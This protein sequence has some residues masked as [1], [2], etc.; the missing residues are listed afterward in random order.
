M[1]Y[2]PIKKLGRRIEPNIFKITDAFGFVN[3]KNLN[4]YD[5]VKLV[6][7]DWNIH[8]MPIH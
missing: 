5:E 7:K 3:Y 2:Y 1:N 6:T 4:N 8:Q